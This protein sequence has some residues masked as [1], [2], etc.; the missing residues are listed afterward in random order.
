MENK[1]DWHYDYV[2]ALALCLEKI[3]RLGTGSGN[4]AE[5]DCL[6]ELRRQYCECDTHT[7]NLAEASRTEGQV[8]RG[9]TAGH[10]QSG[11][12]GRSA[13]FR[14]LHQVRAK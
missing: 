12:S 13:E 2:I 11:N 5:P 8:S 14:L 6:P 7:Q 3:S 9:K 10:L 4:Q 1:Y